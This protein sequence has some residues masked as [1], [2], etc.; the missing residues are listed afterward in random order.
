MSPV[1]A[2][3]SYRVN[4][5]GPEVKEAT[6]KLEP[7]K[8]QALRGA[9]LQTLPLLLGAIQADPRAFAKFAGMNQA[10]LLQFQATLSAVAGA[11][12]TSEADREKLLKLPCA[13]GYDLENMSFLRCMQGETAE[14]LELSGIAAPSVAA[15]GFDLVADMPAI[16]AQGKRGTCVAHAVTRCFELLEFK[17]SGRP[18]PN[19]LDLSEQ[20]LYWN[21]KEIDGDPGE[22]TWIHFAADSAVHTGVCL[23]A[24]MPYE[25]AP[26]PNDPT[27]RGPKPDYHAYTEALQHRPDE[28][29]Q[30]APRDVVALQSSLSAGYAIAYAIPVFRSWYYSPETRATGFI[31]MPLG[32]ADAVVGG[33]AIALTGWG[34]DDN[35][36]GGGYF[37]LDNSWS[38][39]WAPT[40]Q[41]G[42]GRGIL[43]FKYAQNYG[44]EAWILRMD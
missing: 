10:T 32:S 38:I 13:L 35:V 22:G 25:M 5:R 19:T 42:A 12:V 43:P 11:Q 26:Y 6:T 30:I 18:R 36:P 2:E 20:F 28:A 7:A 37:I 21:T 27:Q 8:S 31:T 24:S 3:K 16:R 44:S 41:F 34:K 4:L 14:S 9:G 17:T 29:R 33:H 39:D 40:N 23:E 15:A 1:L